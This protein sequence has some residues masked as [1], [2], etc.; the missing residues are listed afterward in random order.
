MMKTAKLLYGKIEAI[1]EKNI[2][3]Q[4]AVAGEIRELVAEADN[5]SLQIILDDVTKRLS[6][7]GWGSYKAAVAG[8]KFALEEVLEERGTKS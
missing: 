5:E 3:D 6:S 4:S 7:P 1:V 2:A 8:I